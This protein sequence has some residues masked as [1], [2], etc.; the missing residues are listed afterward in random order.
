MVAGLINRVL[1]FGLRMVLTRIIGDKGIGLFQM[2]FPIF[3]TF[4][5]LATFGLPVAVSKFVSEK[6]AQKNQQESVKILKLAISFTVFSGTLFSIIFYLAAPFI[7][8]NILNNPQTEIILKAIAPALFFITNA[9]ILRG[10][11]QGLR[12][13]TP[14][15]ISQ[16]IEQI[17]RIIVTLIIL[18]LL[19]AYSLRYQAAGLALGIT[20]GEGLGL[21]T[22]VLLFFK[23]RQKPKKRTT[24]SPPKSNRALLFKKLIKFGFPITVSKLVASTTYSLEAILIPTRLQAAGYSVAVATSLYGQL[25]G[26]ALQVIHLPM[27]ITIAVNSNLIPAISEAVSNQNRSQLLNRYHQALRLVIY[28]GLP[29]AIIFY[30]LPEEICDILF[31]YPEAGE[32]LKLISVGVLFLYLLQIMNGMLQ[33]LGKPKLVVINSIIGLICEVLIIYILVSQPQFGLKGAGIAIIVRYLVITL[34]NFMAIGKEIGFALDL[35]Q[36]VFK[37]LLGGSLLFL[38]IPFL[39]TLLLDLGITDL[40]NLILSITGGMLAYTLVLIITGGITSR[41]LNQLIN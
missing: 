30:S 8:N 34:L 9:S 33:G 16:V 24:I 39:E 4:S 19:A 11:F 12:M 32:I 23:L 38:V 27:V 37:P 25:S 41:D 17:T 3:L 26:M 6:I 36:L 10:F 28:T 20:A 1:G 21:L 7:A 29:A 22:L 15:A 5:I 40:T 18:K 13:M 2:I 14:T 31:G 35:K